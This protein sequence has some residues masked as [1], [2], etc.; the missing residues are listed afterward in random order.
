MLFNCGHTNRLGRVDDGTSMCDNTPEEIK[1]K[2]TI[3]TKVAPCEWAEI[4][5][6][7]LDTP[8]F[9][10]FTGDILAALK[11]ADAAVIVV[12]A[13]SGIQAVTERV[14]K[15]AHNLKLPRM[16]YINKI[17]REN[18]NFENLYERLLKKYGIAA[19]PMVI[20][21]GTGEN[22]RGVIDLTKMVMLEFCDN[23]GKFVE[24]TIPSE[25]KEYAQKYHEK[26]I[27]SI[28]ECVS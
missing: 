4:K 3:Q 25:H 24:K 14:A 16:F 5:I 13:S 20:P 6:N 1:H 19:A 26:L 15:Y 10:D 21:A 11:V 12:C 17:D 22:F 9:S 8:G 27:E 7:A 2:T 28:V 23:S 18:V